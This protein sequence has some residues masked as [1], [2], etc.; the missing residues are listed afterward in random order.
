MENYLQLSHLFLTQRI[1]FEITEICHFYTTPIHLSTNGIILSFH[2]ICVIEIFKIQLY[3]NFFHKSVLIVSENEKLTS[4]LYLF[5]FLFLFLYSLY[6]GYIWVSS[7]TKI[8]FSRSWISF[9]IWWYNACKC[10]LSSISLRFE[11]L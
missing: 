10:L 2:L 8:F 4:L 5:L 3:S 11:F 9:I 6:C 7:V 1:T